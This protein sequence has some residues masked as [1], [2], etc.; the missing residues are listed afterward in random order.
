MFGRFDNLFE[1]IF[2]HAQAMLCLY[3]EQQ[4]AGD[5]SV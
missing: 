3:D 5:F 4:V 2:S 1:Q